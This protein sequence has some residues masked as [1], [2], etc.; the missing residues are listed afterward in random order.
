M[1]RAAHL[2]MLL[3]ARFE[4]GQL[5]EQLR[6]YLLVANLEGPHHLADENAEDD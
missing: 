6:P 1:E 2:D 4:S 3:H 5:R